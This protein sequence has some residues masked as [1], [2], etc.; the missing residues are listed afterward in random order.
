MIVGLPVWKVQ[1]QYNCR[2]KRI[3]FV[4]SWSRH[5]QRCSVFPKAI[6]KYVHENT[7][8]RPTDAHRIF[9][10]SRVRAWLI[11]N[12][13]PTWSN[14]QRIMGSLAWEGMWMQV[15]NH[16]KPNYILLGFSSSRM[17]SL[18]EKRVDLAGQHVGITFPSHI[19]L[20]DTHGRPSDDGMV[21]PFIC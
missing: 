9:F 4:R 14:T 2:G 6:S 20:H 12:F 21:K 11:Y 19:H 8:Q 1:D 10:F 15:M 17:W 13:L 16:R 5:F 7:P 3:A 18:A